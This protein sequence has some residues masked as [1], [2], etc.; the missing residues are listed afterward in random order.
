LVRLAEGRYGNTDND[1][2][3]TFALAGMTCY[4][5]T[6]VEVNR[7]SGF[8]QPPILEMYAALVDCCYAAKL[9]VAEAVHTESKVLRDPNRITHSQRDLS[10]LVE[11][12]APGLGQRQKRSF[13]GS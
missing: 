3:N 9:V 4:R 12:K 2:V 8:D 11:L 1:L 6:L 5:Y 10:A 13:P 7:F